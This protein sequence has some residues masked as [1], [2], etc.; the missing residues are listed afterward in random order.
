MFGEI[1]KESTADLHARAETRPF[2]K[3]LMNGALNVRA[4]ARYVQ[5]LEP[6]YRTLEATMQ[7]SVDP[8][9]GIFDHR[10]LDRADRMRADLLLFGLNP[11][12]RATETTVRYCEA[13]T[14]SAGRPHRLL[15]HHYT[16]Y[17][18]D[19]AGGQAISALMQ[20]HYGL[21]PSH[22]TFYD[23]AELGD[24]RHYRKRYKNLMDLLPLSPV[25]QAEFIAESSVAY[26]LNIDLFDELGEICGVTARAGL[27]G[28][29]FFSGERH[30]IR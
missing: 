10:R 19:M 26:Q 24:T 9:V 11:D 28:N 18:G 2:I 27:V 6:V 21:E 14:Q 29:D 1:L 15:A 4:Y 8:I 30:H 23:F 3:D 25:E 5:A 12:P 20:R 17:L 13:I 22:L 7:E 16:R